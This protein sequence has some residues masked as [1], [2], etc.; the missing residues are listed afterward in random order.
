MLLGFQVENAKRKDLIRTF[1][2]VDVRR[3]LCVR[4]DTNI[5]DENSAGDH[6]TSRTVGHGSAQ[7]K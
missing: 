7:I 5:S 2:D 4:V 3:N 1:D 6:D